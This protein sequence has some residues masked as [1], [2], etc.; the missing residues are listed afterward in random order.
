MLEVEQKF[1]VADLTAFAARLA[2]RGVTFG[3]PQLQVDSYFNHPSRD[4]SQTDEALRIRQVG[5][6]NY[7]TYKGPKL[8]ATTKTRR[9]IELPISPGEPAAAQFGELLVALGFRPVAA[10]RKLRRK[11]TLSHAGRQIE[12]VLD[13][14]E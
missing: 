6:S 4:F 3:E 8:D 2:E 11:A 5:A 10:V 9:E 13:D 1:R 14:V 7:V 12:V